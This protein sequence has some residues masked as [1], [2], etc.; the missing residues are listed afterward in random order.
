[1]AEKDEKAALKEKLKQ[2]RKE[3]R[4]AKKLE[5]Q[6]QLEEQEDKNPLTFKEWF[7]LEGI[8]SEIKEVHWLSVPELARDSAIVLAFTIILGLY[9]YASDAIIAIILRTLGMS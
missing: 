7:S 4:K 8:R 3:L 2:E 1:M 6:R 9:F 5:K